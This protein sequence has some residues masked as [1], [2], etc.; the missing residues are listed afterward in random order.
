MILTIDTSF[1]WSRFISNRC[2]FL[3]SKVYI[4]GQNCVRIS[5]CSIIHLCRKPCQFSACT[6]LVHTARIFL[7]FG[8]HGSVPDR[9]CRRAFQSACCP[10]R[11][12]AP[13]ADAHA[14]KHHDKGE[15]EGQDLFREI[16]VCC[17]SHSLLS[18][19]FRFFVL[20]RA[21]DV[22]LA[23]ATPVI[24]LILPFCQMSS[25]RVCR[26]GSLAN[27]YSAAALSCACCSRICLRYS[28]CLMRF[29]LR[30]SFFSR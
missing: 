15:H 24:Y 3:T 25:F 30:L 11:I 26:Q 5:Y 4:I 17:L 10:S 16:F 14:G 18:S 13:A 2:P 8:F 29:S 20:F 21:A 27:T 23:P 1:E 22:R 19:P 12:H 7:R 9:G 6:N 28:L